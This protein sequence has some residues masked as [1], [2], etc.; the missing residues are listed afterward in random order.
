M[1]GGA[2]RAHKCPITSSIFLSNKSL[3]IQNR[4]A[5]CSLCNRQPNCSNIHKQIRWNPLTFTLSNR[6]MALCSEKE[7]DTV[8][9]LC[10]QE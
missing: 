9:S 6:T 1:L 8:S 10:Y 5:T 4:Q 3:A 7:P 2:D